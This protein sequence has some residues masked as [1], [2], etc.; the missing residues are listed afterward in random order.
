MDHTKIDLS[1]YSKKWHEHVGH[2]RAVDMLRRAAKSAK[3]RKEPM[4][5]ALIA[6]PVA[7]IGKT[8]LAVL[9]SLDM[10]TQ[11]RIVSGQVHRDRARLLFSE[12][13]DGDVLFYNEFH[14]V[15]Q[16]GR[17][18]AEWLLSYLEN[19]T[20]I[21]PRGPERQPRVTVIADTTDAHKIPT[22][23]LGRFLSPPIDPYTAQE[24]AKIAT[25]L[26]KR[27]L[28][29]KEGLPAVLGRNAAAISEAA[30]RNPRAMKKILTILRDMVVTGEMEDYDIPR[31]LEDM[32]ITRDGLDETAQRYLA[33]LADEFGGTAGGATL[34]DRLMIPGGLNEIERILVDKGLVTKTRTGRVIT[35]AGIRRY[36]E[37][38]VA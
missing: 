12:L 4:D 31:L 7:G 34:A 6:S 28:V 2:K 24:G 16:G 30:C 18:N 1:L 29:A 15:M 14:Q 3:I 23:I 21:G 19:G 38:A 11:V 27:L 20:I 5:H 32:G 22:T 13:N 35:Q 9:T 25:I 33:V 17:K 10:G 26:S 8:D 37:L 36:R